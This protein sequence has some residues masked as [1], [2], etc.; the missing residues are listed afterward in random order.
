MRKRNLFLCIVTTAMLVF[1]TSCVEYPDVYGYTV[2]FDNSEATLV[3]YTPTQY[4]IRLKAT[5]SFF[6]E[7][8]GVSGYGFFVEEYESDD[9]EIKDISVMPHQI[10]DGNLV[11]TATF[12]GD[13]GKCYRFKPY[14][15]NGRDVQLG[16]TCEFCYEKDGFIPLATTYT[17]AF[18]DKGKINIIIDYSLPSLWHPLTEVLVAYGDINLPTTITNDSTVIA[19]L[20][21]SRLVKGKSYRDF[22][23]FSKNDMGVSQQ[24]GEL[25]ITIPNTFANSYPDDGE[26]DD[27]IR[28]CGIDWAKGN[29]TNV[30]GEYRISDNQWERGGRYE[31]CI[32]TF[33]YWGAYIDWCENLTSEWMTPLLYDANLLLTASRFPCR[34]VCEDGI[35]VY[36]YLYT[37]PKAK[38]VI[39][40]SWINIDYKFVDQLGLFLP[41]Y[42]DYNVQ[43]S[44]LLGTCNTYDGDYC[45]DYYR[46]IFQLTSINEKYDYKYDWEKEEFWPM[47]E[48]QDYFIRPVKAPRLVGKSFF[49]F[50]SIQGNE[51]N[52][53]ITFENS[54]QCK[55]HEWGLRRPALG[56]NYFL[57]YE[58]VYYYTYTQAGNVIYLKENSNIVSVLFLHK[59]DN[60]E[61]FISYNDAYHSSENDF[62]C[63]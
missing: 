15:T 52:E 22:S 13:F 1:T 29:L 10:S 2:V 14:A 38:Q 12:Q 54:E 34:V 46:F 36:G 37:S 49:K 5:T 62:K 43:P 16:N 32:R 23:V 45:Y 30:G 60:G 44:Y 4:T 47:D 55:V 20:D 61:F 19:T 11:L 9:N 24:Y 33:D 7:G 27:C 48:K 63:E 25:S 53:R 40:S 8:A 57:P 51:H 41:W 42:D 59:D 50:Y 3:E 26:K 28:L 56:A 39:A 35:F 21:L 17:H 18:D 58:Y 6:D 31:S